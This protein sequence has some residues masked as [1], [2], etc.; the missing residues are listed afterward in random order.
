[1]ILEK[2]V[3]HDPNEGEVQTNNDPI[4]QT[5]YFST[6]EEPRTLCSTPFGISSLLLQHRCQKIA[7]T[8]GV[9]SAASPG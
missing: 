9:E 6:V 3:E 2:S 8:Y 1:M 4:M 5:D 7:P